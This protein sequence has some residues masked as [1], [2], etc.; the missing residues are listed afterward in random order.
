M[1]IHT[2]EIFTFLS[3]AEDKGFLNA[4]TVQARRTACSKLFSVLEDDEQRTVEYVRDNLELIKTRFQHL[5]NDVRG[6]T[7]DEYGRRVAFVINDFTKWKTD[8]A[9]WEKDVVTRGTRANTERT[10]KRSEKAKPAAASIDTP[11]REDEQVIRIPLQS[12]FEVEVKLPRPYTVAIAERIAYALLT[13]AQDWDPNARAPRQFG[14]PQL[15]DAR[16]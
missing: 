2:D 5:N 14:F 15:D 10:E 7:V 11:L 16:Q 9:A 3:I 4:N 6:Q 12:G 8:R 13:L 1:S